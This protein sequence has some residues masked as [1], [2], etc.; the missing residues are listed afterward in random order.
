MTE[1][2]V[3]VNIVIT[4]IKENP[5]INDRYKDI[6]CDQLELYPTIYIKFGRENQGIMW[7]KSAY[8]LDK[9]SIK[10]IQ[11]LNLNPEL[12]FYL[13]KHGWF[14]FLKGYKDIE[15]VNEEIKTCQVK[16][17]ENIIWKS[18]NEIYP[19]SLVYAQYG[20]IEKKKIIWDKRIYYI[21][22]LFDDDKE[23]L[24]EYHTCLTDRI[25]YQRDNG[26]NKFIRFG[27]EDIPIN[28]KS[29]EVLHKDY[30]YFVNLLSTDMSDGIIDNIESIKKITEE[31]FERLNINKQK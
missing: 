23:S 6:K 8:Q 26:S 7:D 20:R 29:I 17:I 13:S 12:G 3:D 16:D 28:K 30:K 21:G 19:H 18:L 11:S 15:E 9:D 14:K 25:T 4:E 5:I 1:I 22:N 2:K 10:K 27:I 24:I 31:L